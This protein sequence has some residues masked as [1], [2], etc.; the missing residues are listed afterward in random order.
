MATYSEIKT[1]LN[2]IAQT[3]ADQKAV[4]AKAKTNAANAS[5]T[6]AAL[7]SD[8]GDVIT[9]IN[10]FGTSNAAEAACKAELAKLT[11]EFNALKTKA[12][13]V[14]ALDLNS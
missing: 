1:G 4:M 14:A 2:K 8:Y 13:Q 12:D 5:T 7:A 3:I 11:A 6:L 10:G 9:T